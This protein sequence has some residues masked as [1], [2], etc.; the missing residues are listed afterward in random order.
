RCRHGHGRRGLVRGYGVSFLGNRHRRYGKALWRDWPGRRRGRGRGRRH[1]RGHRWQR[2]CLL[3]HSLGRHRR[4]RVLRIARLRLAWI[5]LRRVGLALWRAGMW[6][7][8]RVRGGRR[9]HAL[10]RGDRPLLVGWDIG[11]RWALEHGLAATKKVQE[12][13]FVDIEVAGE[14]RVD[15]RSEHELAVLE[16]PEEI[17]GLPRTAD[18]AASRVRQRTT[19]EGVRPLA[20]RLSELEHAGLAVVDNLVEQPEQPNTIDRAIGRCLALG[21]RLPF[22][23]GEELHIAVT[24]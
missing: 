6:G 9:V 16:F 24:G 10:D 3:W 7:T 15:A 12:P 4:L 11:R 19:L 1:N 5:G 22:A 8:L 18:P 14:G 23:L 21:V 20:T 2:H 13:G 17:E